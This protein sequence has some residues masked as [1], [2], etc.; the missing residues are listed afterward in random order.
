MAG[1]HEHNHAGIMA[2]ID[3]ARSVGI[4]TV[5]LARR[6]DLPGLSVLCVN[7]IRPGVHGGRVTDEVTSAALD[8]ARSAPSP[9]MVLTH[10]PIERFNRAWSYPPGVP[11]RQGA[12]L[13]GRLADECDLLLVSSGHTHSHRLRTVAGV[14]T[15]EV[16]SPKDFPGVCCA[17]SIHRRSTAGSITPDVPSV[18][19]GVDGRSDA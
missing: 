2:P 5:D 14:P 7:T 4:E 17:G 19:S 11:H 15:T 1:N 13:L 18:A 10:H 8:L 3:G 12:A 6:V 16:G 9:V